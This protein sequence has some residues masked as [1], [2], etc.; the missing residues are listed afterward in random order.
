MCCI[1]KYRETQLLFSLS[2]TW[3]TSVA[4][5]LTAQL[6]LLTRKPLQSDLASTHFTC[7]SRQASKVTRSSPLETGALASH[8]GSIF[9]ALHIDGITSLPLARSVSGA[10][11][12]ASRPPLSAFGG[13]KFIQP[14]KQSHDQDVGGREKDHRRVR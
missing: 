8:V 11:T 7:T 4:L 10:A 5:V 12:S 13:G 3:T 2:D 1:M 9:H 6:S 14:Q